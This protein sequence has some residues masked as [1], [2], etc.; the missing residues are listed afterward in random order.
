MHRK[1]GRG[2]LAPRPA[3]RKV[4]LFFFA[5]FLDRNPSGVIMYTQG[6]GNKW[7]TQTATT[8]EPAHTEPGST[9]LKAA[10][11]RAA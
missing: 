11:A 1:I 10:S 7:T 9:L 4:F 6:E 2:E 5:F 3:F 8:S